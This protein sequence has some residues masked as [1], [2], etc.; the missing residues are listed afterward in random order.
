MPQTIFHFTV[1]ELFFLLCV[2]FAPNE[3]NYKALEALSGLSLSFM[4]YSFPIELGVKLKKQ[5][6]ENS[7]FFVRKKA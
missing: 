3:S 1:H 2:G 6:R 4:L 7:L 5:T